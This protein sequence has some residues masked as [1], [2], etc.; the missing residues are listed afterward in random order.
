MFKK[1]PV[2]S[3]FISS[4]KNFKAR[5]AIYFTGKTLGLS[6]SECRDLTKRVPFFA[7]PS[8]LKKIP[9]P[10]GAEDVW[11][12]AFLLQRIHFQKSLHIGGITFT[13]SPITSYLPI[14]ISA[15]GYPM[16]H[17]DKESVEEIGIIKIDLLGVRGLSTISETI[18]RLKIKEIPYYDS[19][20]F[21]LM[22]RGETI[23]CF[24]I[25][26]PAMVDLLRKIKPKCIIRP[27]PTASGIKRGWL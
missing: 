2:R 6:P 25:E 24:Q 12:L 19:K 8:I 3:S 26:S 11:K 15:K 22:G 10:P 7:E 17:L 1:Y 14:E 13:P 16:T 4:F 27:G 21:D 20:T 18:K 9:S 23:G 5:S